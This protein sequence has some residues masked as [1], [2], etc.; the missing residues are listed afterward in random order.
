MGATLL[1]EIL[2]NGVEVDF[3]THDMPES[4]PP[5]FLTMPGLRL[6]R[7]PQRWQYDR[8]YSRNPYMAFLTS[9]VAR[10]RAHKRLCRMIIEENRR[11]PYDLIFQL[12]QTELFTLG[13]HRAELPPIIVYPCTHAAGELYW[14]HRESKYALQVE[15]SLMHY[16]TR[17]FLLARSEIQKRELR[18]PAFVLGMSQRF[19]RLVSRDYGVAPSRLGVLYHPIPTAGVPL[20]PANPTAGRKLVLLYI[21]RISVRKGVEQIIELSKRL[22]DLADQVEI[23][24]IGDRT[25]WSDYRG[26]LK[27]LNPRTAH[28]LGGMGHGD[29]MRAYA[30]GDILLLP[31]MYEPGGIVVGE[32]LSRGVCVVASDEVGSA[33]VVSEDCCRQFPAGDM[34]GFERATRKLIADVRADQCNLRQRAALQSVEHFAPPKIARDLLQHFENVIAWNG[35]PQPLVP[36]ESR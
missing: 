24:V 32:A 9:T 10:T 17:A 16:A 33:E 29:T 12:S 15:S 18:K 4:L 34:D 28:Y 11:R 7:S 27:E 8:W 36:H 14:H 3:Y 30:A 35:P 2:A 21:A 19:N 5:R 22:D 6:R 25:Q 20:P 31:S 1:E 23:R 13:R 26:H